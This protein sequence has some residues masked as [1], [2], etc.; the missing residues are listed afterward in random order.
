M[1][2]ML[3]LVKIQNQFLL[4]IPHEMLKCYFL[5]FLSNYSFWLARLTLFIHCI[6]IHR[7]GNTIYIYIQR[8]LWGLVLPD[9]PAGLDLLSPPSL[10]ELQSGQSAHHDPRQHKGQL[11]HWAITIST[12]HNFAN[13]KNIPA[14]PHCQE[15]MLWEFYARL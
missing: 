2:F 8:L 6:Y 10:L 5:R 13:T 12:C 11:V 3:K 9:F 4:S 7:I 14:W 1:P 15:V